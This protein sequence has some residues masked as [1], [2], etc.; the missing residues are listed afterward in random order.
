MPR[1][2][3]PLL[4]GPVAGVGAGAQLGQRVLGNPGGEQARQLDSG[5]PVAGVSGGAEERDGRGVQ[6]SLVGVVGD[7]CT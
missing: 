4:G 5:G 6:A 7:L 2:R 3:Q 1:Q